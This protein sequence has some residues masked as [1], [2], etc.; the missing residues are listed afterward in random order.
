MPRDWCTTFITGAQPMLLQHRALPSAQPSWERCSKAICAH[1]QAVHKWC[2]AAATHDSPQEIRSKLVTLLLQV[3]CGGFQL[4]ARQG[5]R[6]QA[7]VPALLRE[8]TCAC[9]PSALLQALEQLS[10]AVWCNAAVVRI[11]RSS[12]LP[13]SL[14]T[15][16]SSPCRLTSRSCGNMCRRC[17]FSSAARGLPASSSFEPVTLQHRRTCPARGGHPSLAEWPCQRSE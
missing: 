12:C 10:V 13:T 9:C 3:C 1:A 16:T 14:L 6:L 5:G 8:R 17:A 2:Q 7:A 11:T 4:P 15:T